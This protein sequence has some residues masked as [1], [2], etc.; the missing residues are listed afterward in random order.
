MAGS[1]K[2]KPSK[3]SEHIKRVGAELRK[4]AKAGKVVMLKEILQQASKT[5]NKSS[6]PKEVGVTKTRRKCKGGTK[7]V[8]KVK[9]AKT[10]K[11]AKAKK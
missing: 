3:W 4:N 8:K 11:K 7:K 9:R 1:S 2:R 10:G 6:K 5:Y